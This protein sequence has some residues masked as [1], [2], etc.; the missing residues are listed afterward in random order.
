[1]EEEE[2]KSTAVIPYIKGTSEKIRRI[3][4][5]FGICTAFKTINFTVL[6]DS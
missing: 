3:F 5:G 2:P 1:M 6:D 4:R